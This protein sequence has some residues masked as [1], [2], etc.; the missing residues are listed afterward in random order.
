MEIQ[1]QLTGTEYS[2]KIIANKFTK[3]KRER[4]GEN[5]YGLSDAGLDW[6]SMAVKGS[7][8]LI[9]PGKVRSPQ[10]QMETEHVT[11]TGIN[12]APRTLGAK[13]TCLG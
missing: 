6:E 4:E 5:C 3:G 12:R 10:F 2:R 9:M 8:I 13:L 7:T 1:R 11:E